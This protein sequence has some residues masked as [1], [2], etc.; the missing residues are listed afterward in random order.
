MRY[1]CL[2]FQVFWYIHLTG[3]CCELH[4]DG[5]ERSVTA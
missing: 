4:Y 5:D 1:C 2:L 3:N